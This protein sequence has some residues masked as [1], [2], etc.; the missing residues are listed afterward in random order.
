M[1]KKDKIILKEKKTFDK[2]LKIYC[3]KKHKS[4]VLCDECLE[5]Q[6]YAHTRIEKCPFILDKPFCA[7]CKVH[8]YQKDMRE[9]VIEIM[10]YSGSKMIFRAPILSIK[11]VLGLIKHKRNNK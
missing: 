1:E 4:K 3:K 8:C 10:R 7:Y 11:H 9:K 5:I 2:M 6:R